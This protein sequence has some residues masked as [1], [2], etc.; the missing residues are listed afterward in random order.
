M[1]VLVVDDAKNIKTFEGAIVIV[2]KSP[3]EF[4]AII[5]YPEDADIESWHMVHDAVLAQRERNTNYE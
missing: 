4:P 1:K 3:Y 2:L 5:R